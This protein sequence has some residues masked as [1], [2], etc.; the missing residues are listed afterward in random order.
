MSE[1]IFSCPACGQQLSGDT[2]QAGTDTN[3]P[4]CHALIVV[5]KE[6]ARTAA[7]LDPIDAL[8]PASFLPAVPVASRNSGLAIASLVCS[9][10]SLVTCVGWLPGIICGHL[11]KSR[12]RRDP[13]L[14]G[15]GLATAGLVI[16]YLILA[17]EVGTAAVKLWT[18]SHA[19]KQG[20]ENVRQ[21]LATNNFIATTT[22]F[23]AA[24][25][26]SPPAQTTLNASPPVA[27][28][29]VVWTT[30]L[31]QMAFPAHPASG[32]LHG[33]DFTLKTATFRNVNLKLISENG[34]SLEVLGLG[35][36]PQGQNY[37]IA[38]GDN[39]INLRIRLT[40]KEGDTVQTVT[41]NQGY[42]LKLD[43]G[44]AVGRKLSGKIYVC[45]PD[46][47]KSYLAGTFQVL[48][49]KPK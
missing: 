40:W 12:L 9:L 32:Q 44:L 43:F 23:Q 41:F 21:T 37:E 14:K 19:V 26:A 25:N 47:A 5:P 39:D 45:L 8:P 13:S 38:P 49:P 22:N 6:S 27:A 1:F 35:K 48:L 46:D 34:L 28:A 15:Q 31:D 7:V 42:A 10:S 20:F 29:A 11:A 24:A 17:L 30:I 33:H 18:F 4:A 2:E 3:C 36:S 16:G